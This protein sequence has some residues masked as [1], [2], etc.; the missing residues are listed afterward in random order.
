MGAVVQIH[1]AVEGDLDEAVAVRLI[2]FV[3]CSVG[4]VYGKKGKQHLK[5]KIQAYNNAAR[6]QPWFVLV[7]L[8][9]DKRCAPPLRQEWLHNPA[10]NLCFR[11]AVREVEAWLL[12]D[13]ER[14]AVFLGVA[15]S[16]IP[17]DP[18]SIADPKRFVV[19]LAR[20]SKWRDVRADI[21][22]RPGSGREE[23]PA[24]SSRMIEFASQRWRPDI[25]ARRAESLR[26]A[27]ERLQ[28]FA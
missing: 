9:Q 27:I 10:P 1:A 8:D 12:A 21:V 19:N 6:F 5:Q 4:S 28:S 17:A 11:I 20:R 14:M 2:R 26:R 15:A 25:A 22:P 24:Y 18:E 16:R 7:D 23:G 13:A 3:G